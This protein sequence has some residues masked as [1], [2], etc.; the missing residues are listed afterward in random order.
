MLI[1]EEC[2]NPKIVVDGGEL[3]RNI[4]QNKK[5]D[6]LQACR[7]PLCDKCYRQEYFFNKQFKY[8][9]RDQLGRYNFSLG[10]VVNNLK[11]RQR[12]SDQMNRIALI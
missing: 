11:E 12:F 4:N 2:E 5:P 6:I 3:T 1:N 7:C 8:C 10:L 9:V